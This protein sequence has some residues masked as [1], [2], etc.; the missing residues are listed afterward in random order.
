[1]ASTESLNLSRLFSVRGFVC[2][3]SGGGS[4]IGLMATQA[5]AANGKYLGLPVRTYTKKHRSYYVKAQV[6]R[7]TSPDDVSLRVIR[8]LEFQV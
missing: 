6:P 4:G 1:M 5:L 3:V 7:S 2:I 8:E